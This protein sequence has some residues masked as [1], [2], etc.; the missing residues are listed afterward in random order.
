M[1]KILTPFYFHL[2]K[3]GYY[4]RCDLNGK[5]IC[6]VYQ[7]SNWWVD[8]YLNTENKAC[9][10]ISEH[11]FDTYDNATNAI[12]KLLIQEGY[13]LLNQEQYDKMKVFI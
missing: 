12:D 2:S 13:S 1:S 4:C 9:F 5:I 7:V 11:P 10:E 8:L 6:S 3:I